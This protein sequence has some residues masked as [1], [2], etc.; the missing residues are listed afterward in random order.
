MLASLPLFF[1]GTAVLFAILLVVVR[2]SRPDFSYSWLITAFGALMV[3]TLILIS[4]IFLPQEISLNIWSLPGFT[5]TN[6]L[7]VLDGVSWQFAFT[8]GTILLAVVL[9]DIARAQESDWSAWTAS[10]ILTALGLLAVLAGNPLTLILAW[11]ALDFAEIMVLFWHVRPSEGRRRVA[12]TISAKVISIFLLVWVWILAGQHGSN[13]T[14]DDLPGK[15]SLYLL[16]AAWIRIG[17][18]PLN[19]PKMQERSVQRVLGTLLRLISAASVLVLF[20]RTSQLGIIERQ[21]PYMLAFAGI[22]A[23]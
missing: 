23:L 22:A 14:F 9:T 19:S 10:L 4:R 21:E 2:I 15:A 13:T 12:L 16:L 18:I 1:I 3:W 7:L 8:L 17:V 11:A 5:S 20:V 6:A